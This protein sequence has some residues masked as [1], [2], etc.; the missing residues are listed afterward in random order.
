[1]LIYYDNNDSCKSVCDYQEHFNM[2]IDCIRYSLP[3][4]RQK[5]SNFKF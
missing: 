2:Q 3:L 4:Y 1:M 5:K